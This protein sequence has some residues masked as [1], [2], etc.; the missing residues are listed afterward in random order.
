MITTYLTLIDYYALAA[1]AWPGIR[2][3]Q[4]LEHQVLPAPT[5]T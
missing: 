2:E 1:I 4:N 5:Q 3:K